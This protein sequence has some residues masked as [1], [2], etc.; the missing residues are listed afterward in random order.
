MEGRISKEITTVGKHVPWHLKPDTVPRTRSAW[1]RSCRVVPCGKWRCWQLKSRHTKHRPYIYL[2]ELGREKGMV[3]GT[4]YAYELF[5]GKLK[6]LCLHKCDNEWCV[7]PS[8]MYDGTKSQNSKDA[9]SRHPNAA[10]RRK[11]VG[12]FMT[13]EGRRK[14]GRITSKRLRK[15][16]RDPNYRKHMKEVRSHA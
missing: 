4:R 13:K 15:Q 5:Y 11:R 10:I 8:H 12:R 3:S 9:W 2:R 7:R 14:I 1:K 16:W 6:N